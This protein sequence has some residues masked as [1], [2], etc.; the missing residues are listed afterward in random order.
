MT[1]ENVPFHNVL[2]ISFQVIPIE[3]EKSSNP[4]LPHWYMEY[5]DSGLVSPSSVISA[6]QKRAHFDP[7]MFR[8]RRSVIDPIL[9]WGITSITVSSSIQ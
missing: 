5:L 3:V 1:F 2:N 9:F 6:Y 8:K 7:I 4:S